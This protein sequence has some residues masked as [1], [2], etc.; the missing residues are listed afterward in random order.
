M[1]VADEA[2][3]VRLMRKANRLLAIANQQRQGVE[4]YNTGNQSAESVPDALQKLTDEYGGLEEIRKRLR[5][6]DVRRESGRSSREQSSTAP[7][8]GSTGSRS[9][10]RINESSPV[11][12][13]RPEV[14][15]PSTSQGLDTSS[16]RDASTA[17]T[18][19]NPAAVPLNFSMI[20]QQFG[21]VLTHRLKKIHGQP[22]TA[23][24]QIPRLTLLQEAVKK[25]D[26]FYLVLHQVCTCLGPRLLS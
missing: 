18:I 5:E 11:T 13:Q 4:S 2:A 15:T 7:L 23:A 25:N 24:I 8:Q 19:D 10:P 6:S 9:G 21:Q 17:T 12:P 16:N 14:Y 26:L 22:G 3:K 1:S 20:I